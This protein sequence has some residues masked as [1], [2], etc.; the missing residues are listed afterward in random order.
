MSYRYH[1][2]YSV[3]QIIGYMKGKSSIWTAQNVERKMRNFLGHN[4]RACGYLVTT[5]S[6]DKEV[7]RAHIGSQ[8]LADR[9]WERLKIKIPSIVQT[10]L[11]TGFGGSQSN[12]QLCWMLLALTLQIPHNRYQFPPGRREKG[13][14]HAVD[15]AACK[16]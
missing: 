5:V 9:Q 4:F 6:R 16:C 10:Y 13:A 15:R 7:I 8:E 1:P 14:S 12:L 11:N 3:A 2:I